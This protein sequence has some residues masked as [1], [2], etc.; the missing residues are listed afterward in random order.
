MRNPSMRS[1]RSTSRA[2]VFAP[3]PSGRARSLLQC[4]VQNVQECLVGFLGLDAFAFHA[5]R[6]RKTVEHGLNQRRQ[7]F[8][9]GSLD[10][11]ACRVQGFVNDLTSV[12]LERCCATLQFWIAASRA[13]DFNVQ[14]GCR[15]ISLQCVPK[16]FESA[17]SASGS[18]SFVRGAQR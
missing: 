8:E 10:D 14:T 15:L 7:P 18:G 6:D 16:R 12:L 17:S 1:V 2:S 5:F 13:P 4:L 3:H 9:V 11:I